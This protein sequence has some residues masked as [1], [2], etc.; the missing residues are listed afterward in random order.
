M[1][2]VLGQ[3]TNDFASPTTGRVVYTKSMKTCFVHSGLRAWPLGVA[4]PRIMHEGWPQSVL[5]CGSLA[6]IFKRAAYS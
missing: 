3:E 6:G 1:P 2:Q 5:T 4:T